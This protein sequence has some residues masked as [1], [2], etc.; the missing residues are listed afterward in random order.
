MTFEEAVKLIGEMEPTDDEAKNGWTNE[1]LTI[2][3]AERELAKADLI[4][5]PA[6]K[7]PSRTEQRF[8]W[9]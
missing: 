9:P 4:L 5:S 1:S 6:A 2:Y 3:H 8:K 7:K